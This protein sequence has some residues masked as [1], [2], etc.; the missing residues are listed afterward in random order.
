MIRR[1]R[2]IG[3]I[4]LDEKIVGAP[5]A[6]TAGKTLHED[7]SIRL[8]TLDDEVVIASIK[9]KIARARQR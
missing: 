9:S 4:V 8:W 5:D 2:R 6:K 3:A 1:S 7:E